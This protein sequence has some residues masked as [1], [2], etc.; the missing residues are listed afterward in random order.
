MTVTDDFF[1]LRKL[2]VEAIQKH[3]AKELETFLEKNPDALHRNF[4]PN[5][6]THI[7]IFDFLIRFGNLE[8]VQIACRLGYQKN[9]ALCRPWAHRLSIK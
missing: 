2:L 6:R 1:S 5:G 9:G 7:G 4:S 8:K 3:P